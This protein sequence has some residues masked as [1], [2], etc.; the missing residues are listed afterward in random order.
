MR[1][2]RNGDERLRASHGQTEAIR[3]CAPRLEGHDKARPAITEP[4]ISN[5]DCRPSEFTSDPARIAGT[6]MAV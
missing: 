4:K 5:V 2:G 3:P 1:S 6:E